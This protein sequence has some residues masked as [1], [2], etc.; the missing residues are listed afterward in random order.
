[1]VAFSP[2]ASGFLS[3]KAQPGDKYVGDD[4]RRVITRFDPENVSANQ[5]LVEMLQ[6]FA[7]AKGAT[8]AQV[9]LAWMLAKWPFVTPIPGA[10]ATER[11]EENL[12]AADVELAPGELAALEQE[13][14][15]IPIHGNR[16]D[17]DIM[18]LRELLQR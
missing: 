13:L 17:E 12:S 9:S 1:F 8:P 14:A 4:V 7:K 16:I 18:K 15:K 10:R 3:G 6:R 2:L 11:I 5:P